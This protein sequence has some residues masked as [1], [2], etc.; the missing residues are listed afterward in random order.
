MLLAFTL[1][2]GVAYPLAV[3]G[4]AW[5]M[6]HDAALG[7]LV[8]KDGKVVGSSLVGQS[9]TSE[10][11]FHPR[12]SATRPIRPIPK[13]STRPTTRRRRRAPT[14]GRSPRS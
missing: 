8:V 1:L 10:N 13:T 2:T 14:S 12:P 9:F 5:V 6:M 11:Y 3:T 4:V 7:S